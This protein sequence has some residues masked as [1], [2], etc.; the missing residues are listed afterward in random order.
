MLDLFHMSIWQRAHR[1]CL[2]GEGPS[3]NTHKSD[4]SWK[5]VEPV[6]KSSRLPVGAPGRH[7]T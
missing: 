4:S 7:L 5:P 3:K 2:E 1:K 6:G